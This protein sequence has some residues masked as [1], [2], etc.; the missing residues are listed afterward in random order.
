MAFFII[1]EQHKEPSSSAQI[2]I[3]RYLKKYNQITLANHDLE[4]HLNGMINFAQK[5]IFGSVSKR[6]KGLSISKNLSDDQI[7][8]IEI[9]ALVNIKFYKIL[10]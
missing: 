1:I 5:K 3:L 6:D 8:Y 2:E 4:L 7:K 9:N 10:R